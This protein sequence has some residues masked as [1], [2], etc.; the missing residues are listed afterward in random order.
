MMVT[1]TKRIA[2]GVDRHIAE[3]NGEKFV[4]RL[5]FGNAA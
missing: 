5:P 2:A 4:E 3:W 1:L